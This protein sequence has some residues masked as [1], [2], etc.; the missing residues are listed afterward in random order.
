MSGKVDDPTISSR[1]TLYI[2][3]KELHISPAEAYQMPFSLVR[4]LLLI[5]SVMKEEEM[6][7][8]NKVKI[9]G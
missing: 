2:L 7:Q 9:N 4:D 1:I 6:K 5:H 3:S 8:Y